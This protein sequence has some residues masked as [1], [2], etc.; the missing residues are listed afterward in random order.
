MKSAESDQTSSMIEEKNALCCSIREQCA[1]IVY[2][3]EKTENDQVGQLTA[4]AGSCQ[5]RRLVNVSG[6]NTLVMSSEVIATG[7]AG[8][9]ADFVRSVTAVFTSPSFD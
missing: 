8:A 6:K 4:R 1:S 2:E 9:S 5:E 3:C 7:S